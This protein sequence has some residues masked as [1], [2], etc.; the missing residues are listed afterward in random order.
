MYHLRLL[1]NFLKVIK[2]QQLKKY[3]R[4]H[5]VYILIKQYKLAHWVGSRNIQWNTACVYVVSIL[6][7]R[8]RKNLN[9]QYHYSAKLLSNKLPNYYSNAYKK[10]CNNSGTICFL[11]I[12]LLTWDIIL[13]TGLTEFHMFLLA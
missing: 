12:I 9:R 3:G 1:Q 4:N 11:N 5:I 13:Y 8:I 7:W 10:H 2:S 6:Q